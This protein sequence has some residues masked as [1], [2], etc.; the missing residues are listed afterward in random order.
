M[1]FDRLFES[2]TEPEFDKAPPALQWAGQG[3]EDRRSRM[4]DRGSRY[5][6]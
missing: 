4:E 2:E 3:I 1:E 5:S 6:V